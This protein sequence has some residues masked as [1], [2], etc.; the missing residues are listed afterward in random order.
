MN[1]APSLPP[2]FNPVLTGPESAVW[3]AQRAA[4]VAA[5][6]PG[7]PADGDDSVSRF[8]STVF[9]NAARW[10][11]E[12]RPRPALFTLTS[13]QQPQ[14]SGTRIALHP[15]EGHTGRTPRSVG[16]FDPRAP[17]QVQTERR[18]ALWPWLV[19]AAALVFLTERG[20]ALLRGAT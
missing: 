1:R 11:L 9:L 19:G 18:L 17:R 7:L 6:V 5:F 14:P 4:P 3:I 2:G 12:R 8:A 10:V 13:P 16:A 20:L 15:G